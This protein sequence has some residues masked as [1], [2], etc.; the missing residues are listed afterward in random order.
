MKRQSSLY[1]RPQQPSEVQAC[2]LPLDPTPTLWLSVQPHPITSLYLLCISLYQQPTLVETTQSIRD[3]S[4]HQKIQ[5][6]CLQEDLLYSLSALSLY[7][8]NLNSL[9]IS[10][11]AQNLAETT[12]ITTSHTGQKIRK[13]IE[14]KEENINSTKTIPAIRTQTYKHPKPRCLDVRLKNTISNT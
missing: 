12:C 6:V 2:P 13:E 8:P 11:P 4:G 7:L 14:T 5:L 10:V 3:H 1:Q 9:H